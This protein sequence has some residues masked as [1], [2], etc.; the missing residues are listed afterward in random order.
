[1]NVP[2]E[3]TPYFDDLVAR[4]KEGIQMP[5]VSYA[6]AGFGLCHVNAAKYALNNPGHAVVKGWWLQPVMGERYR[7]LA[8]SVVETSA[9]DLKDVTP[10]GNETDRGSLRFLRHRGSDEEF[11]RLRANPE[12]YHPPVSL[13]LEHSRSPDDQHPWEL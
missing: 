10:L 8:H 7:V 1:M 11:E 3:E 13:H 5:L 9:G 2:P 12:Y 4:F 6:D